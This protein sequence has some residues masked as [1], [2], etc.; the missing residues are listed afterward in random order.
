V[1]ILV[2]AKGDFIAIW[3]LGKAFDGVDTNGPTAAIDALQ[4]ELQPVKEGGCALAV[5]GFLDESA[6]DAGD[7]ELDGA[8]VFEEG[9]V[10]RIDQVDGLFGGPVQPRVEIAEVVV[11]EGVG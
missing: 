8:A 3:S 2:R 4:S 5:D 9:D 7:G 6:Q 11:P 10:K 1:G